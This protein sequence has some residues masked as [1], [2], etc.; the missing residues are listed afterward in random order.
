MGKVS[1]AIDTMGDKVGKVGDSLSD[2]KGA[3]SGINSGSGVPSYLRGA[4]RMGEKAYEEEDRYNK[5]RY[6]Y[7]ATKK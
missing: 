4:A 2:L 3:I 1:G 7:D 5:N 6:G